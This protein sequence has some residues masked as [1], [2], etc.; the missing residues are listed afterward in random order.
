MV[1]VYQLSPKVDECQWALPDEV[2]FAEKGN[3]LFDGNSRQKNWKPPKFYIHNPVKRCS[4]FFIIAAGVFACDQTVIEHPMMA[5]FFEMA[6]ELLPIELEDGKHLYILNTTEVVNALDQE[7]SRFRISP[8]TGEV[9]AV[10]QQVFKPERF[11]QSPIFKIPETRRAHVL[12]FTGRFRSPEEEFMETYRRSGF[13]GLEF[14][15]I[16]SEGA[17]TV[18]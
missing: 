3:L 11:T 18:A 2:E 1:T 9:V 7:K 12:T 17:E 4:N 13:T 6:G 15:K 8:S 16:W 14:K 10:E 5:M